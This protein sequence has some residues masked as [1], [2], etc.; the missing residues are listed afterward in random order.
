MNCVHFFLGASV[1][2]HVQRVQHENMDEKAKA[3]PCAQPCGM[4]ILELPSLSP[5]FL[6]GLGISK[7]G[8]VPV[9]PAWWGHDGKASLA[10]QP[11]GSKLPFPPFQA[12]PWMGFLRLT[13]VKSGL[14]I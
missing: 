4:K 8:T 7:I 12:S 14:N 1:S 13:R 3:A 6:P 11:M 10:L 9:I 5:H 2:L